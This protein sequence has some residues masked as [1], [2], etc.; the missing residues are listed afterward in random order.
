MPNHLYPEKAGNDYI[1][2]F[3]QSD[4]DIVEKESQSQGYDP[5]RGD[6]VDYDSTS[7][8]YDFYG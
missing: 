1:D 6:S 7:L 3:S 2:E 4:Y 8:L 5:P